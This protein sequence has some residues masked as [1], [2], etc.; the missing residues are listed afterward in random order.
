MNFIS[1]SGFAVTMLRVTDLSSYLYCARKLY[2]QRVLGLREPYKPA[3]AK[4][5]VRHETYEAVVLQE[6]QIVSQISEGFTLADVQ[7]LYRKACRDC[8]QKKVE[9]YKGKLAKFGIDG[10]ELF[11]KTLPLVIVEFDERAA[12][13]Y[14]F[15]ERHEVYG[16]ELWRRLSPKIE[17]EIRVESTSLG[18]RGIVDQIEVYEQGY[19]PVELK[20]GKMPPEGVW[21]GHEIQIATYALLLQ[22]KYQTTI[23]EG[24]VKYLDTNERRHLAFNPFTHDEVRA[25]IATVTSLLDSWDVPDIVENRNKCSSCGLKQEC[26]NPLKIEALLTVKRPSTTQE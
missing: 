22:E 20:T 25:L 21:P 9:S 6:E 23:K 5:S 7:S 17:T 14:G 1:W 2:L 24:F 8:L 3:L 15:M 18:I 10:E 26:Y 12:V 13:V 16:K 4:G 11:V 19:V